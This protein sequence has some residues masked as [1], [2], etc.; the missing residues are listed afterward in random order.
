VVYFFL[1]LL[2]TRP[3]PPLGQIL[4]HVACDVY[5]PKAVQN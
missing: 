1:A 3:K 2:A 4:N 5:L